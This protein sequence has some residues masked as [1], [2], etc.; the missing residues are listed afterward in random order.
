MNIRRIIKEEINKSDKD[1]IGKE[2]WF[3]YHCW[4]SPESCD[5]ELWYRSHQK[6]TVLNRGIDDHDEYTEEPKVYDVVFKDGFKGTVF[7][8][9]LMNSPKEFYRPNPPNK[10]IREEL[11]KGYYIIED[12]YGPMLIHYEDLMR[13]EPEQYEV[14]KI[15]R[16][17]DFD[18]AKYLY[19]KYLNNPLNEEMDKSVLKRIGNNDKIHMSDDDNLKFKNVSP[20]EQPI[21]HKP[22]G[23]WFSV[24]KQWI[25]FLIGDEWGHNMIDRMDDYIYDIKTNDSKILTIGKE[26]ESMFLHKYGVENDYG[27]IDVDWRKVAGDWS[28]V[29][30]LINPREL[31]DKWLWNTWD[32]ASGCIWNIDGIE[33]VRKL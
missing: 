26:N 10:I 3:E 31:K 27:K 33:S 6:V 4:E 13:Q 15:L 24:G 22:N 7:A 28:G 25:D 11:D 12:E 29:E 16:T 8:D 30:I 9:E 2:L 14:I 17:S 23:L 32:I 20:N 5:A 18:K 1:I 21:S 19:Y